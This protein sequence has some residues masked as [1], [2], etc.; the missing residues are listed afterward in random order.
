MSTA[1]NERFHAQP[2][3]D[4]QTRVIKF[5]RR[6][7]LL[8][9]AALLFLCTWFF[10]SDISSGRQSALD[11]Q[12]AQILSLQKAVTDSEDQVAGTYDKVIEQ[13]TGGLSM[14]HKA[15]DDA[16]VKKLLTK[17]LT[18]DGLKQYLDRREEVM[19][20]FGL[21]EDSQ[22]MTVFMPGQKEGTS[23]TAPSGKT[24]SAFD[25]DMKSDFESMTSY[26][27]TVNGDVYS[28]FTVVSLRSTSDSGK[29]SSLG[30][31]TLTYEVIDGEI[32]NLEATTAPGGV[33]TSG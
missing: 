9:I 4:R 8:L 10:T 33:L 12:R 30:Y 11:S 2:D 13:A 17:A 15:A 3:D 21:A 31:A 16:V 14:E 1:S 29:A 24:Y 32:A 18:W 28:Y 5:L 26:V 20:D 7:S 6:N 23:R 19:R 27:T 22:F 25:K